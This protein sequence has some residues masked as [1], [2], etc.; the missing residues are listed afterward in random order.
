MTHK[1]P[2]PRQSKLRQVLLEAAAT[3][4][5]RTIEEL[6]LTI[7]SYSIPVSMAKRVVSE[8]VDEGLMDAHI[9]RSEEDETPTVRLKRL[10]PEGRKYLVLLQEG[11][12][13]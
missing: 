4:S 10:T 9:D 11:K 5:G 7:D 3:S 2:K 12:M 13:R 6:E 1:S 8:L